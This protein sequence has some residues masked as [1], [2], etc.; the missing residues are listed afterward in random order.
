MALMHDYVRRTNFT[1]KPRLLYPG[2]Q[3]F[4]PPAAGIFGVGRRPKTEAARKNA[5]VTIKTYQK[6]ETALEK[7]LAPR[8][9]LLSKL[10]RH[11]VCIKL[12]N[13]TISKRGMV[14]KFACLA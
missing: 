6:P 7:S 13:C 2:Y 3:R 5:R 14:V 10:L 11:S 12:R 1:T 8:V 4:F 9:R